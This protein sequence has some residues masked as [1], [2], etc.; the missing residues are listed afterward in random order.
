[1]DVM[2][3]FGVNV[4]KNHNK[5]IVKGGMVYRS[6]STYQVEGDASSASYFLAAGAIA[7]GPVTVTGLSSNSIQGDVKFAHILEK[8]GA[9]VEWGDNCIT[10][11]ASPNV[12]KGVDVDCSNIPDCAMTLA[13]VAI[14]ASNP[15][16]LRNIGTW[17]LKECDRLSAMSNEL[18]KFGVKT[19]EGIDF[20]TIYP[21]EKLSLKKGIEVDT[22]NDHRMAMCFS[23]ISC[24]GVDVTIKNPKCTHKTFPK[25]FEELFKIFEFR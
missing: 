16:T 10:V 4:S 8:M 25:F 7:G 14:F 23:L 6:P 11:S 1:M 21:P 19:D 3:S 12:L 17:R 18:R 13:V 20:L 15:T 9:I 5:F 22:Y 24:A 2:R